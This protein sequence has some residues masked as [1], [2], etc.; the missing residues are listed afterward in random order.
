M[1]RIFTSEP[2][3]A[4]APPPGAPE[5]F[6]PASGGPPLPARPPLPT[7]ERLNRNVLTVLAVVM[8]VG[9][10]A[11]VVFMPPARPQPAVQSQTGAPS[12]DLARPTFLD[13]PVRGSALPAVGA[14]GIGGAAGPGTLAGGSSG[15][16]GAGSAVLG[17]LGRPAT[18]AGDIAPPAFAMPAAA[19]AP[20]R[21]D[22][23]AAES[24]RARSYE[25]ALAAPVTSPAPSLSPSPTP[26]T[27]GLSA[28]AGP[29]MPAGAGATPIAGAIAPTAHGRFLAEV[30]ASGSSALRMSVDSSPGPYALQAGTM[31]PAVLVTEINSDLP[32][33]ILAQ[34]ARDVYD[35]QRQAAL[36]IPKGSKLLGKYDNQVTV[37]EDRLLVAWTRV[38]FP[39][40]RSVTLPGL[41]GK[42]AA[43]A[44][45]LHDQVDQHH[46][47]VLGT[48]ALLSLI[49][50]GAQ[51]A[52]PNGGYGPYGSYP[53][54]PGQI[55]AGAAGQQ[56]AQVTTEMLRRSLDMRPTIRIRQGTPFNVFLN[57][58]VVFPGP[59]AST[60]GAPAGSPGER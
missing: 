42:D 56:M 53:T 59:Y 18:A 24:A 5:S 48:A 36:L 19:E 58:D 45:G 29:V 39:D 9:V 22:E 50:A 6:T 38:I 1:R 46:G 26:G 12:A 32:G 14:Q 43:G 7:P 10:L 49:G 28:S 4:S 16:S 60:A 15:T 21:D 35:S 8:G 31:I 55:M 30:A 3:S 41:Q 2:A 17:A 37:G 52:Q 54:P 44:G 20:V 57:T 47:H 33:E 11:A 51:L 40:G 13:Q 34:V 23:D 27:D 25:A